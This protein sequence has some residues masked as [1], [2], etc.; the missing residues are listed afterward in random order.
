MILMWTEIKKRKPR[1]MGSRK[2]RLKEKQARCMAKSKEDDGKSAFGE[3]EG[4][5]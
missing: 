5:K 1:L 4:L 2:G 3:L